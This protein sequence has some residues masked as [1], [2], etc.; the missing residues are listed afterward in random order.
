M[1]F[2]VFRI[3]IMDPSSAPRHDPNYPFHAPLHMA[4]KGCDLETVQ[5]MVEG[6]GSWAVWPVNITDNLDR[7]PLHE[8]ARNV[9]GQGTAILE[10]LLS[11]G[12]DV[13]AKM[14]NGDTAL[15]IASSKG[16]KK[17][18]EVLVRHGA[19]PTA[20]NFN[21]MTPHEVASKPEIL[22]IL[23]D[24]EESQRIRSGLPPTTLIEGPF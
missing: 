9:G 16:L 3:Q 18:V 15:H 7:I 2:S 1:Y 8:A 10:Y 12:A 17:N 6:G 13:G 11:K 22:K 20:T 21:G 14:V 24:A 5:Q 4:A 23:V 19:D